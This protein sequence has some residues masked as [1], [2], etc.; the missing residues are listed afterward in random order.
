M[1][2]QVEPKKFGIQANWQ[3]E[4]TMEDILTQLKK[5]MS[6][7]H[8]RNLVQPPEGRFSMGYYI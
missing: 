7:L 8:N 5:E 3:R 6:A 4:Y 1:I 2:L